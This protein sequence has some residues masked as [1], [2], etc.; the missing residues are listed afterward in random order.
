MHDAVAIAIH[1]AAISKKPV[2]LGDVEQL[3]VKLLDIINKLGK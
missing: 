1:N 3:S 2:D